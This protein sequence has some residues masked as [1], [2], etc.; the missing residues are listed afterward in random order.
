MGD[1][2]TSNQSVSYQLQP[3]DPQSL[4]RVL[5]TIL[6]VQQRFLEIETMS[7]FNRSDQ[8]EVQITVYSLSM[9]IETE[10]EKVKWPPYLFS[11]CRISLRLGG[12]PSS[13]ISHRQLLCNHELHAMS[14]YYDL[15]KHNEARLK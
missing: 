6:Y 11:L 3:A 13:S 1:I 7:Q 12:I 10:E 9:R 2:G 8:Q 4:M 5:S 15:T 14:Y